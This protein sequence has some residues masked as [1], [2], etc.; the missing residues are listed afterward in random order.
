MSKSAQTNWDDLRV[1]VAVADQGSVAAAA[2]VL[3]LNHATVLRR[4]AAFEERQG[5]RLFEKT[6]RGY[7]VSANRRALI[8]AIREAAQAVGQVEHMIDAERPNLYGGLRLTSTDTFCQTILPG[9]IKA[10]SVE[11]GQ[12]I[13]VIADNTHLDLG[14]SQAHIT[15]RPALALPPDLEGEIGAHFRFGVYG[16]EGGRD[17][18]LGLSG[19]P[20]RSAAGKW[21]QDQGRMSEISAD[22]FLTLA[23]LAAEGAGRALLPAV[24]G[25]GDPRLTRQFLVEDIP[26]LPIWVASHV[27]YARSG[28]LRRVRKLLV[29]RVRDIEPRL[30]GQAPAP[31]APQAA[32]DRLAL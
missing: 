20:G 4:I 25:D 9:M 24:L 7:R 8:E 17:A 5:I 12:M 26:P 29:E 13:E 6:R 21:L 15:V 23:G 32:L 11:L 3:S 27:D 19:A 14:R 1:V 28:R 10:L 31:M 30:L 16:T 2:R 22:S 18:W